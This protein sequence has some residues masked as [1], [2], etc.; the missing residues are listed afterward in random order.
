MEYDLFVAEPAYDD[1]N[2]VVYGP[3]QMQR[4]YYQFGRR[5][6]AERPKSAQDDREKSPLS[7]SGY[8]SDSDSTPM[9]LARR[10][11]RMKRRS[12]SPG[13]F[14][15]DPDF[16][17]L[18]PIGSLS[19][20]KSYSSSRASSIHMVECD[21]EDP[22]GLPN[23]VFYPDPPQL[24]IL[25]ERITWKNLLGYFALSKLVAKFECMR[26]GLSKWFFNMS[27]MD[28]RVQM[29]IRVPREHALLDQVREL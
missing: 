6:E 9:N 21:D 23:D 18:S 8:Y 15:G 25:N 1:L 28:F 12:Y 16:G 24:E 17:G 19:V 29:G 14:F 13:P 10:R 4:K 20:L 27:R 7:S 22:H 26:K 11:R 2:L 5:S 3:R